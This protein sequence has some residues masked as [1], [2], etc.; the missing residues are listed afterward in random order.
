MVALRLPGPESRVLVT[1]RMVACA[2]NADRQIVAEATYA[3][4]E[5][6]GFLWLLRYFIVSPLLGPLFVLSGSL[7]IDDTMNQM[8]VPKTI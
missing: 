3:R 2:D 7:R 6:F 8:L 5:A 4:T 1:V